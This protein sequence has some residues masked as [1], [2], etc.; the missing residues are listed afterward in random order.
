MKTCLAFSTVAF[1]LA[2]SKLKWRSFDSLLSWA[3]APPIVVTRVDL[4]PADFYHISSVKT[5]HYAGFLAVL[6][7][8][9]LDTVTNQSAVE[10]FLPGLSM[11]VPKRIPAM[12]PQTTIIPMKIIEYRL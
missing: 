7:I 5:L 12:P 4:A 3:V 9:L 1:C 2:S 10:Y 11:S 6:C 8:K